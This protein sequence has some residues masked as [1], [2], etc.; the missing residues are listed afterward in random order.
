MAPRVDD[1][2][3]SRGER[4]AARRLVEV[5]AEL[6]AAKAEAAAERQAWSAERRALTTERDN[7]RLA[8]RDLQLQLELL[9]RRL[10][11]A[12]A[13]RIDT[14]QLELELG[15]KLAEL[16]A[17]N[18]E[19]GVPGFPEPDPEPAPGPR[20]RPGGTKK[21]RGRRDLREIDLPEE[22]IELTDPDFDGVAELIGWEEACQLLWRRASLVRLVTARAKYKVVEPIV[23]TAGDE[24]SSV[25]DEVPVDAE[26]AGAS[27]AP[28]HADGAGETAAD[29]TTASPPVAPGT[30]TILTVPPAPQLLPRSIG[31][32]SLYARFIDQK[33]CYGMPLHRQEDQF[34]RMG[35]P[36]DRGTMSRWQE[37]LGGVSGATVVEAMRREAMATAFSIL[38]DATGVLIQPARDEEPAGKQAR[39]GRRA[40]QR[41][42]FFVQIADADHVFFEYVPRETS[43]AVAELFKGFSGYVQADAKAVYDLMFRPPSERPPPDDGEPDLGE[44]HE[45]GCWAHCR[46]KAW[47]AAITTKDPVAREALLR[48]QRLFDLDRTWRGRPAAEIKVLRERHLRPHTNAFFAWVAAEYA[49]VKDQRGLLRTALGYAVRQQGPLTRFFDDGRLRLD[50]NASERE[51]RRIAVGRKAWLFIGSDDHA[52]STGNLLTLIASARL[53]RLDSERY[54]RDLFRV[55]PHWPRDRYLE[56]APRYWAATRARL[57]PV[58]LERELGPLVVP[59]PAAPSEQPASS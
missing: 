19:L 43:D 53:H 39:R 12:K 18:R 47:E 57:D 15:A 44:R 16:D 29:D 26:P 56:L 1:T 11:V 23:P 25:V 34:A 10:F 42:H 36:L 46:R 40:C 2:S 55:L 32:P 30:V 24:P 37:E 4:E 21:P 17:L 38:T 28:G 27:V 59:R 45:V 5:E 52:Q 35:V 49:R 9:R 58:Q 3:D 13:E 54:L 51:L 6:A 33:L 41:G 8:Y 31:T 20:P 48:I 50:N 7:L 22:R 14:A